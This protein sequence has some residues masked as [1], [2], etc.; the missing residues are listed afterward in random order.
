MGERLSDALD[1]LQLHWSRNGTAHREGC[2]Y[3]RTPARSGAIIDAAISLA[4][5][6]GTCFTGR[7]RSVLE[8][9]FHHALVVGIGRHPATLTPPAGMTWPEIHAEASRVR[10][11]TF[12]SAD[13]RNR[14]AVNDKESPG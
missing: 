14:A 8:R 5:P 9:R 7:E 11:L 3:L 12:E 4:W 10:S 1:A 6:C 13:I 2:K